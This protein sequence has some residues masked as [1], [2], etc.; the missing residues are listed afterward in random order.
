MCKNVNIVGAGPGGLAAGMILA[1]NGYKVTIYEKE[2]KVGGRNSY[3]QLGDYTFDIGPTF[4]MMKD[5]LETVFDK[6]GKKLE[7][8]VDVVQLDPM[9]RLKFHDGR[10]LY[11]SPDK[12][13]MKET[14]E[15]FSPGSFEGYI[16]YLHK[17]KKKYD[18][19]LPCLSMP[20]G[21]IS[22]FF[23]KQLI[24]SIPY[25][26]AHTSLYN[27]LARYF[28]DPDTRIAFTFQAKYIGM[29]PW[30]APGT[31]SII[32]YIEHGGGI[33][34]ITGGLNQLSFKMSKAFEDLGGKIELSTSV[35]NVIVEN[36]KAK[37]VE[38]ENGEKKLSDYTIINA[39]FAHAM[40]KIVDKK[41]RKKY[42]DDSL[43]KKKYSCS[44]F[45]LYL[46]VKKEYPEIAHHSI[47]FAEDYKKNVDE[48]TITKVL[49]DDTSFYVQN[50]SVTD[51]T[52]APEGH[53][54]IYVLVPV[55]NNKSSIDWE[56]EKESFRN[57]VLDLLETKGGYSDLRENIVEEKIV[58]PEDWEKDHSVYLGATFN[59]AHNVGQMLYFRPHNEFEE[60]KNCYLVGGGTHPGSGLPTIYES[61]RISAELI[62]K[63]D[64]V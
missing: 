8:Y 24:T 28:D 9:Y 14:M 57:K 58:T 48:I 20:Y 4:F 44:T 52:L 35:K 62:M 49:S 37:G 3:F 19:L 23:S 26:D 55:P 22:D 17:E 42:S 51:K 1:S 43:Q 13:K 50:A 59:L 27:V 54:T 2:N 60:F 53:S 33:Y 21:K 10:E 29:S 12:E 47:I 56:K 45:M 36:G 34:H 38:L 41:D 6:S 5:V 18:K 32:S 15:K 46:G 16:R 25:L 7:D 30:S 39:D 11:P 64:G 31:F 63:K 61:G 40:S